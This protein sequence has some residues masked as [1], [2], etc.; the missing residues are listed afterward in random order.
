MEIT[1]TALV[2]LACLL[3]NG[4]ADS[5]NAQDF[6]KNLNQE[7]VVV[8]RQI[9]HSGACLPKAFENKIQSGFSRIENNAPTTDL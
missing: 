4:P 7:Q 6:I 3:S 2:S 1:S 9:V 5:K 8:I